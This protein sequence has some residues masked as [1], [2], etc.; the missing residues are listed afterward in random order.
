[1]WTFNHEKSGNQRALGDVTTLI[2]DISSEI[3]MSSWSQLGKM[4]PI[5]WLLKTPVLQR[6]C[7]GQQKHVAF[8]GLLIIFDANIHYQPLNFK[9]RLKKK[10]KLPKTKKIMYI[11][12]H[13]TKRPLSVNK[14]WVN[15]LKLF[16]SSGSWSSLESWCYQFLQVCQLFLNI[17]NPL[18]LQK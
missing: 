6:R 9:Q 7:N 17:Y 10:V 1:M 15:N 2:G 4:G 11:F 8:Q 16:C 13:Y 3:I 18:S 5:A 12:Q 14:K